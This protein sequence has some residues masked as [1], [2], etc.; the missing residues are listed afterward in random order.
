M[1]SSTRCL[2]NAM[3]EVQNKMAEVEHDDLKVVIVMAIT[4]G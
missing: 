3:S 2:K 1:I 4:L